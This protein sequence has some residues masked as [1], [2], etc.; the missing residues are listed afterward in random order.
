MFKRIG[1]RIFLIIAFIL[2]YS[3]SHYSGKIS[4]WNSIESQELKNQIYLNYINS[5]FQDRNYFFDTKDD[6]LNLT[7][8]N[9]Q[10]LKY[11]NFLENI[12]QI[13]IDNKTDAYT[14]GTADNQRLF[15][16]LTRFES[17]TDLNLFKKIFI[18]QIE[19]TYFKNLT[20]LKDFKRLK[21]LKLLECEFDYNFNP[22]TEIGGLNNLE[23]LFLSN[24][25]DSINVN[26]WSE[27]NNFSSNLNLLLSQRNYESIFIKNLLDSS[28]VISFKNKFKNKENYVFNSFKFY[29]IK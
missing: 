28:Q 8:F 24:K 29:K 10:H 7:I 13:E 18:L 23:I 5:I 21:E 20:G 9:I 22:I 2:G 14:T 4:N 1:H 15:I 25:L 26:V 27:N 19:D 6:F 17:L 11:I 3:F 16:K 12:T